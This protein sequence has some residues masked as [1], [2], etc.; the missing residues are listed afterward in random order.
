MEKNTFKKVATTFGAP[1]WENAI[2]RERQLYTRQNEIR[3][4][5][6]RDYTRIL[7]STA[8]RRLKHK[9]QVFFATTNDHVCTRIEHVNHVNSISKTI[10]NFLGL[11]SELV[12]AISIGHDLGHAPF[13]HKGEETIKKILHDQNLNFDFWHE[14]NSLRFVDYIETLEGPDGNHCNLYLSYA[15]RDGIVCHCGEVDENDIKPREE[16]INLYDITSSNTVQPFTWEGCVVKISDKIAYLGRDIEDALTLGILGKNKINELDKLLK[17]HGVDD[18]MKLNNTVLIHS[19]IIDLC[20]NSSPKNGIR[21]S[22]QKLNLMNKIKDFCYDNIYKHSKIERYKKFVEHLLKDLFTVLLDICEQH[23]KNQSEL[24]ILYPT[25]Y[26]EFSTYYSRYARLN[27]PP[28]KYEKNLKIYTPSER[29]DNI[30]ACVDFIS[31]MTDQY[32]IKRY[33][34]TITF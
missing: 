3:T 29:N 23:P 14:N 19:F 21:L 6:E 10:S 25:L 13:G 8:Y 33:K 16:P 20:E 22:P 24:K 4:P 32:A 2:A 26:S 7:H 28:H 9:T 18:S 17:T 15:V 30:R 11:N 34:E 1:K 31:G 5:F 12:E 27:A